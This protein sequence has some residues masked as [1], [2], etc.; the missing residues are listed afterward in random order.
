MKRVES[1]GDYLKTFMDRSL[2]PTAEEAREEF[3]DFWRSESYVTA[4]RNMSIPNAR[5]NF[6]V[7]DRLTERFGFV[8][9]TRE[10]VDSIKTRSRSVVEVGAATGYLAA[11]LSNQ[12]IEVTATDLATEGTLNPYNQIVGKWHPVTGNTGAILAVEN[13]PNSDVVLAWPPFED[14]MAFDVANTMLPGRVLYFF[15][16]WKGNSAD[17]DFFDIL[18]KQ[19]ISL[20]SISYPT[21]IGLHDKL[22]IYQKMR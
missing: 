18:E 12:G 1:I 21:H 8:V 14:V 13:H 4:L 16:E 6:E 9:P 3:P 2:L 15:G 10:C 17:H 5:S 20:S 11:V 7:R 22:H 19:F